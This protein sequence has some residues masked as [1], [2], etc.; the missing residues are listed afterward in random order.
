M[1]LK[2]V[3]EKKEREIKV[4]DLRIGKDFTIVAGPCS[5]ES[6]EQLLNTAQFVKACGAH[7]LRAMVFKPRT[8][9]YSFQGLG[10]NG[11]AIVK[12]V[13]DEVDIPVVTEVLDPRDVRRV[14][15]I[16]D[17]VQVG[18][19]NMQNF[20]LLK[21]VGKANRP[22]ILKRG[23]SATL[24]EWLSA[25]EYVM[26]EGNHDV[27]LCERGIRTFVT[28]TRF[29]LDLASIPI[30]KKL[31]SLPVVVDPSHAAGSSDLVKPLAKAS[32]VIGSDGLIIE[33]HPDPKHALSDNKQQLDFD[34]FK[35][36]MHELD[37]LK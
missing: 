1:D 30:I 22:V 5:V 15:E 9:P 25:A 37:E 11:L 13:K 16:A 6:R 31:S 29:T 32:K 19:R 27:I 8:S 23:I 34:S 14:C 12:K 20:A 35:E 2:L 18:A 10:I 7:L 26:N 33:V 4:G 21:E 17:V 3:L 36:L 28:E 24:E